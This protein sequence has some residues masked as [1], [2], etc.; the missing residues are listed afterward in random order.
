MKE[1]EWFM[2]TI[3]VVGSAFA[4]SYE[5]HNID[6]RPLVNLEERVF[7]N[8][9]N[10]SYTNYIK[11]N[12]PYWQNVKYSEQCKNFEI[13]DMKISYIPSATGSMRPYI[14]SND[15]ILKINYNPTK[16]L[17]LGDVV[18]N[19]GVLHRIV[20]INYKD[21][22]YN[23]KGDNNQEL[24][25]QRYLFNETEYVVCGVLRGTDE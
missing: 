16:K 15:R 11:D 20:A 10:N 4:V 13:E 12:N 2:L 3:L 14:F 1:I 24:D 17:V 8:T 5:V 21:K 23:M 22:W 18:A 25:S 19:S 7:Y 6:V 9:V